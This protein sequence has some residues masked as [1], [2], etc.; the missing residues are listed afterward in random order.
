MF[1]RQTCT[2]PIE[3]SLLSLSSYL[4]RQWLTLKS[5]K[6]FFFPVHVDCGSQNAKKKKKGEREK[7]TML[8]LFSTQS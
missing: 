6:H 2:T 8:N 3:I 7:Q 1:R 4:S 5:I